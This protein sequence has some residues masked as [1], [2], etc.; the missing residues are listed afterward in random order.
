MNIHEESIVEPHDYKRG[1]A[2]SALSPFKSKWKASLCRDEDI[3]C[4]YR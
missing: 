3:V 2:L 4:T 1:R